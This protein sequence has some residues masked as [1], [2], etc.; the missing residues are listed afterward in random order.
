MDKRQSIMN[1]ARDSF[2][3]FGY[4]ATTMD[5][6]A[7]IANVGKGTIYTF[8]TNKEELFQQIILELLRDMKSK[9]E[10]VIDDN[11][12][13]KLNLH[14]SLFVLLTYRK[15]HQLTAKLFQEAKEMGTKEAKQAI[16]EMEQAIIEYIKEKL[17]AAIKKGF[18]RKCDPEVTAF[19]LLKIYISFIFD[20]EENHQPLE[21]E[22]ILSYFDEY[23]FKGLALSKC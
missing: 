8:F 12:H 6:V 22:Q 3:M 2:G 14:N 20:W 16:N 19:V 5:Q 1:A 10:A 17:T 7:K 21:K 9:A 13:F 4:K 11:E 23:I 18:I 15:D